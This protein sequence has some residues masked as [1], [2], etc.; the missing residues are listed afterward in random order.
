MKK[1][2]VMR[3]F[4]TKYLPVLIWAGLVAAALLMTGDALEEFEIWFEIPDWLRSWLEK[5]RPLAELLLPWADKLV[6]FGLFLVLAVLVRRCFQ[7]VRGDWGP[8]LKTLAAT[9]L[10]IV[11][12]E[13]A[14]IRI[15]GRGWE[16]L[17]VVAGIAGA[18]V[19]VL[20]SQLYLS[21]REV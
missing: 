12:L 18:L 19:A 21:W 11:I 4:L 6:H 20:L 5:L 13:A 9:L 7:V 3:T 2:T 10:Y 1:A 17:D 16:N 15:P 8:V 14:Q